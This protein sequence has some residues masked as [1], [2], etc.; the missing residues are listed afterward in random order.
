VAERQSGAACGTKL[1]L[2]FSAD[3]IFLWRIF[4]ISRKNIF[5]IAKFGLNILTDS[6][7][8]SVKK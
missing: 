3:F 7:F 6:K 4:A 5:Y 1:K 2:K 8:C